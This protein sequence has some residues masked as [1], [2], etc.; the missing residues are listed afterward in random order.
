MDEGAPANQRRFLQICC[1]LFFNTD[2]CE[3]FDKDQRK[4][5]S[6]LL[7]TIFRFVANNSFSGDNR[8]DAFDKDQGEVVFEN[9]RRRPSDLLQTIFLTDDCKEQFF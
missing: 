5:S 6:D 2:D 7:Q 8:E 1:K 4:L 9:H 3:D